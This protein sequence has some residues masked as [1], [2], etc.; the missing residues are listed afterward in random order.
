MTPIKLVALPCICADVFDGTDIVRPGGEAL[1]FAAHAAHFAEINVAL[2]GVVGQDAYADVAMQAIAGLPID[3]HLVRVDSRYPTANNRTYLT[4]DGDRYYKPDSWDGRILE[5]LVLTEAECEA[6]GAA[7]VVFIHFYASCFAQVIE[8][9][10]AHG[11]KLAVDFD[12]CRDFAAMEQ[13]APYVDFFMISGT[14][15][16]LPH[17]QA[18]SCR[19]S[20]LFNVTLAERGSVTWH[21][22]QA[23]RVSAVP[24][25]NV[26]DTTGGGDSYHAGFVCTYLL[27]NDILQAMAA[28]SSLASKTISHYGGF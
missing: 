24:V 22:G 17:F 3:R 11:F 2:L 5:N 6:I 8:L 28:G 16:L 7:D 26:V 23:Y 10:K 9:K 1:N 18:M 19:Y 25:E 14:E 15:E 4:P 27:E 12:V 13:A 21:R 20:G